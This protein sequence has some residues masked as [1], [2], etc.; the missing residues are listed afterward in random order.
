[1]WRDLLPPFVSHF[2]SHGRRGSDARFAQIDAGIPLFAHG[3]QAVHTALVLVDEQMSPEQVE[4]YRRM[5]PERRLALAERLYWTA[6][7]L[8]TAWVRQCHTDWTDAQVARE[9]TRIFANAR[10]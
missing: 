6:R 1:M 9:V 10:T 8:K 4:V 7:S 3:L 5:P 2:V